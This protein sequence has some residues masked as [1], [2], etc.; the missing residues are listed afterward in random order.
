M[1]QNFSEG[2][3]IS[4][5]KVKQNL[6]EVVMNYFKKSALGATRREI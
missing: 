3:D 1:N 5:T 4:K 2:Y 6:L